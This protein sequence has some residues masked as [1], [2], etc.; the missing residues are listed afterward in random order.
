MDNQATVYDLLIIGSGPA[1]LT[2]SIYASRY[3]LKHLV[4]GSQLGGAVSWAAEIENYPGF[5]KISGLEL[6]QKIADHVQSLGAEI[7]NQEVVSLTKNKDFFQIKTANN[8][9]FMA[10]T[11]IFASGTQRRKLNIPGE[12]EYLG[13]GVSYCTT[14]DGAFFKEKKVAIVGGSNAAA[15][16]ASHLAEFANQVYL[17]YRKEALRADPIWTQRVQNDPKIK[18]IYQ[19]NLVEILGDGNKVTGVKLDKV[20]E[21]QDQLILDGVFI[22]IG[23][24]PGTDLVGSIGVKLDEKG[25]IHV[26]ADMRTNIDGI[27]AA[28]D[29]ANASGEFQQIITAAAEGALAAN[30]VYKYLSKTKG[31]VVNE[32][33]H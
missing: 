23:G 1:G 3:R 30:S 9:I 16:G 24:V 27:W 4:L 20:Y 25:F 18:I 12:K 33:Q 5:K 7:E 15:M 26:E 11:V 8:Q 10:K 19:T 32:K 31:G 13:K 14:C 6:T 28:G 29:V 2:A 17:I 21:N 22:E